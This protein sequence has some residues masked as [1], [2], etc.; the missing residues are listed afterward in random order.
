MAKVTSSWP[1]GCSSVSH[2]WVGVWETWTMIKQS[3]F[4]IVPAITTCP[5][6]RPP[7]KHTLFLFFGLGPFSSVPMKLDSGRLCSNKHHGEHVVRFNFLS[8]HVCSLSRPAPTKTWLLSF[9]YLSLCGMVPARPATLEHSLSVTSSMDFHRLHVSS[10]NGK[11]DKDNCAGAEGSGLI[12]WIRLVAHFSE[13][14]NLS[15]SVWKVTVWNTHVQWTYLHALLE[16]EDAWYKMML[17]HGPWHVH[18]Q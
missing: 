14:L 2:G 18:L 5:L 10:H 8:P 1:G 7:T 12:V 17:L 16:Q 6:H 15:S 11:T 9:D 13:S 4:I 3:T